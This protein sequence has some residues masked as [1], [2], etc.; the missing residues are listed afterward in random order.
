LVEPSYNKLREQLKL[1]IQ[2]EKL[3]AKIY[4]Q[5]EA[6][7]DFVEKLA[8]QDELTGAL[9]A[10]GKRWYLDPVTFTV[11]SVALTDMLDMHEANIR[12]GDATV[13]SDLKRFATLLL[14]EFKRED[15]FLVIR[16]ARAGDE[17]QIYSSTVEVNILKERF[18][19]I[20]KLDK[21][22]GLLAWSY[23]VGKNET[24]AHADL[25][26]NR[27]LGSSTET[28]TAK[29][30]SKHPPMFLIARPQ[31][32]EYTQ[33]FLLAK[34]IAKVSG[35]TAIEDLHFTLQS[36]REVIDL[37]ILI[38]NLHD[39]CST[40]TPF[41]V[42]IASIA[43]INLNNQPGRI[44]FM[45]QKTPALSNIYAY[46]LDISKTLGFQPYLFPVDEWKPHMKAVVL[47]RIS[48]PTTANPIFEQLDLSFMVDHLELTAQIGVDEWKVL[49]RFE[50]KK[51]DGS[52]LPKK[53]IISR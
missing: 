10:I 8:T 35:G 12:F 53:F 3:L 13:D 25:Y 15:G 18:N 17:F 9:N 34:E 20:H 33:L 47:S 16:S 45:M 31:D 6:L 4:S 27:M 46:V 52:D 19:N 49:E 28:V 32:C 37:Q 11:Q 1:Y 42:N 40:L 22:V 36:M 38:K 14:T 39:Y 51:Y 44:W 50:I 41:R 2:D 5:I 48:P 7:R 23:G 29:S 30:N 21:M 26:C 43:R 24:E